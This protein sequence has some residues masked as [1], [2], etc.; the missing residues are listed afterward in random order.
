MICYR[1]SKWNVTVE[2][3]SR[4]GTWIKHRTNLEQEFVIGG[5]IP[6]ARGFDALLVGDYGAGLFG[7][8]PMAEIAF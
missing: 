3:V 2:S 1:N 4:L 7:T 6:G 8:K 5:S